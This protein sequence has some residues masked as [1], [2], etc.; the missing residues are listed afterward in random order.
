[1]IGFPTS[2]YSRDALLTMRDFPAFSDSQY[3]DVLLLQNPYQAGGVKYVTFHEVLNTRHGIRASSFSTI[4]S[5]SQ[6]FLTLSIS[7]EFTQ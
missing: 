7:S 4:P 5:F 3:Q 2:K 1:M 6:L